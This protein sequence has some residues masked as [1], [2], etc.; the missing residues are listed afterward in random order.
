MVVKSNNDLVISNGVMIASGVIL[1]ISDEI[2][3]VFKIFYYVTFKYNEK[4]D[5]VNNLF[6]ISECETKS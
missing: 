3:C 1:N 4:I 6:L 2:F 5:I